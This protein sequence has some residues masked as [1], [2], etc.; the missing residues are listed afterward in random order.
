[1]ILSTT[2]LP[3][4]ATAL[5]AHIA[6]ILP[7]QEAELPTRSSAIGLAATYGI[8]RQIERF[9]SS[10]G[11]TF[12][13]SLESS[14]P[15]GDGEYVVQQGDCLSTIAFENGLLPETI[16]NDPGN[17]ALKSGRKDPN[18]LFP[19]DQVHIPDV[20]IRDEN[21]GTD[22]THTFQL[23]QATKMLRVVLLDSD[24]NP[25]KS[26]PYR[27]NVK[28]GR[29]KT[30]TTGSDGVVQ[31]SILPNAREAEL[32]VESDLGVER[33][34]LHLGTIDPATTLSGMQARLNNIGYYCG[35]V[36]GLLGP[37]TAGALA[38][39]QK[40]QNLA[41]SGEVD[42]DTRNALVKQHGF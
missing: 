26:L 36:D 8:M 40:V 9:E 37:K 7:E 39:F 13:A 16:W 15:V 1:M 5:I 25:R 35:E 21:C 29:A 10:L 31:V 14:D 27:V 17:A 18:I 32:V 30:G 34:E 11:A 3:W 38:R 23:K 41:V 20:K 33:Y 12:M 28:G 42:D 22:A 24:G 6:R 2:G 19:G 4:R